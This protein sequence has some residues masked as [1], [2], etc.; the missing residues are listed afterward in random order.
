MWRYAILFVLFLAI[1]CSGGKEATPTP[2]ALSRFR[3]EGASMDPTFVNGDVLDVLAYDAPVENG[4]IIVFA[5]PTSPTREFLKR[6]IAGPGDTV[7]IDQANGI[8]FVNGE[9]LSEP[10]VRGPTRCSTVCEIE[11]PAA[12]TDEPIVPNGGA[13]PRTVPTPPTKECGSAACYFVMGD[14]RQ[15]SSDSRQGW[16]VPVE[17]II[18]HIDVG[19]P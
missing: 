15:N 12:T 19:Q 9:E 17:N 13:D 6:V 10:Y 1:A 16:P 8:V 7:F 3:M 11:V 4:D 14:N 5:A 18:G 2:S